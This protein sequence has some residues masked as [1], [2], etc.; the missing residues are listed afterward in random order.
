MGFTSASCMAY[1]HIKGVITPSVSAGSNHL[2]ARVMCIAQVICPAGSP[3]CAIAIWRHGQPC[4]TANP[5]IPPSVPW[6]KWRR[7]SAVY[8]CWDFKDMHLLLRILAGHLHRVQSTQITELNSALRL[9]L[10]D[11]RHTESR[12]PTSR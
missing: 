6:S 7:V 1:R 10:V 2:G 9:Q 5:A 11:P 4:H 12:A 3:F 8:V